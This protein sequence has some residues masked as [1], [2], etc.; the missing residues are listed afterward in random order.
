ML[1]H[2]FWSTSRRAWV[3]GVLCL[4]LL[5][6][7]LQAAPPV[8]DG[9]RRF[10][11]RVWSWKGLKERN[12]VMQSRDYSCGA[13]A[14][15]T[16]A[17][18]YLGDDVDEQHFLN[19]LDQILTAEEIADRI[20]NGLAMSDLRRAAVYSGYQAAVARM[21][22]DKI[23]E[24][25]APLLVGIDVDGYKHFVVYRG[26]DGYWVYLADPIRGNLRIS[27]NDFQKQWQKQ[28]ALAVAKPGVEP[29]Q[30]SKLALTANDFF[31]GRTN[32]QKVLTQPSRDSI[33]VTTR[34]R[35]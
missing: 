17:K 4:G 9:D 29:N 12:I 24:A 26:F 14:L 18:Y 30:A 16:L 32:R 31:L 3:L 28:L 20:E 1:K 2:T 10:A 7:T 5:A 8:R 13:A 23:F 27:A 35:P 15:A 21:S 6:Q 19:V 25:T 22:I 34:N 11:K 33:H